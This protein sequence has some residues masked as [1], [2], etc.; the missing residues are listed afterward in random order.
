MGIEG[1]DF[2]ARRMTHE[3]LPHVL[4]DARFHEPGVKHVAKILE[5]E[6]TDA[7]SSDRRFPCGLNALDRTALEGE[8]EALRF[9][10]ANVG[11]DFREPRGERDLAGLSA[12]CF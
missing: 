3:G 4:H 2:F 6:I 5:T 11:E 10:A 8:Y 1:I 12:R 9:V 7:G